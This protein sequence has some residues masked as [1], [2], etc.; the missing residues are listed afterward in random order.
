MATLTFE[1]ESLP[2]Y[3]HTSP[4]RLNIIFGP[5]F[6]SESLLLIEIPAS[7]IISTRQYHRSFFKLAS[8]QEEASVDDQNIVSLLHRS[9]T[10]PLCCARSKS[11]VP[12]LRT[13]GPC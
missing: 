2:A 12:V 8:T 7:F 3:N 4:N 6:P 5:Q 1:F 13:K 11:N 10:R 9:Q